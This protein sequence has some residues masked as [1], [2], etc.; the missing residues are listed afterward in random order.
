MNR[1]SGLWAS[2]R[3]DKVLGAVIKN[4]SYL[5]SGNTIS[6]VLSMVQSI[7][8]ARL[9]GVAGFG[10][11]GTI[12]VFASTINRLFS[13]RMGEM[14]VKYAGEYLTVGRQD[15]AAALI[16][17]A[18]LAEAATSTL[19]FIALLLLSPLAAV[20]LGKDANTAPLFMIYGIS[21]L[22]NLMTE[23]STGVLQV[24]DHFRSQAAINV[25]QSILTASIIFCAFIFK[26]SLMVVL[27]AYLLG[28]IVLGSGPMV[29]A[30]LRLKKLLGEGW[31]KAR[32]SLLPDHRELLRFAISTNLSATVNL[33][34]RDSEILWVSYFLSPLQSGYYKV[35]MA[36]INLVMMPIDPF[37]STT[38]PEISRSIAAKKW[39]QLK[40]L[41]RRVSTIASAWTVAVGIGLLFLGHWLISWYGPQYQPAFPALMIL[42]IGNGIANI[43]FWN[44]PLLLALGQPVFPFQVTFWCGLVK[45]ALAFILVPKNGYIAEAALLSGYFAVSVIIIVLRGQFALRRAERRELL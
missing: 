16:K 36:I 3:Q 32:L 17:A 24:G 5:L 21:I 40:H 31:W 10:L 33:V 41:L 6:M 28:K 30:W 43:L 38:F 22:G 42:L 37:I 11:L 18:A 23:T 39:A 8:A 26:G 2:W 19:A 44:R 14:V 34:V 45:V 13:F 15:R 4:S 27:V 20:Y 25:S 35:A 12:T 1:L 9:L 29:V 7:L